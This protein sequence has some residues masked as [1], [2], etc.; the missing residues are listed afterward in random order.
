MDRHRDLEE[1][2]HPLLQHAAEGVQRRRREVQ[3][4]DRVVA[5]VALPIELRVGLVDH[6]ELHA[7]QRRLGLGHQG[8]ERAEAAGRRVHLHHLAVGGHDAAVLER[9]ALLAE[10]KLGGARLQGILDTVQNRP[11]HHM[12]H[13]V[14]EQ[15]RHPGGGTFEK[16]GQ[17]AGLDRARRHQPVAEAEDDAVVVLGVRVGQGGQTL[18]RNG[19]ARVPHQRLV[20]RALGGA[21]LLDRAY[22][23]AQEIGAQEVVGH[24]E[25][26]LRVPLQQVISRVAPEIRHGPRCIGGRSARCPAREA[27][28]RPEGRAPAFFFA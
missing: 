21:G 12:D 3:H 25:V 13:L 9:D 18:V 22:L 5:R 4:D 6:V 27:P 15:R 28:K 1:V 26:P 11:G 24:R 19:L 2:P 17:V 20:E 10:Q 14:D 23:G 16:D 8:A 7:L